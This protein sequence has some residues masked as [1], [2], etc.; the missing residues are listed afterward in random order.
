MKVQNIEILVER[1]DSAP[2]RGNS[3]LLAGA[4]AQ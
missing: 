3:K 4:E 2:T 1:L